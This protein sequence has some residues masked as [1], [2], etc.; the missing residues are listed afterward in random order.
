MIPVDKT[1]KDLFYR[2]KMAPIEIIKQSNKTLLVNI[3]QIAK[4]LHRDPSHIVKYMGMSIGCTQI[5]DGQSFLLNGIFE[6]NRL[7]G[8][9]F[10]YIDQFVLCRTCRNPETK[11]IVE[12]NLLKRRCNSCGSVNQQENHKLIKNIIKDIEVC[13]NED[14]K[15]KAKKDYN[16]IGLIKEENEDNSTNIYEIFKE[17]NLALADLFQEYFKPSKLKQL[18]KILVEYKLDDIL[19]AIETMLEKKNKEEKIKGFIKT[20]C[21][22]NYSIDDIQKFYA[23]Q[24]GKKKNMLIKKNAMLFIENYE[25]EDQK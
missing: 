1:S 16:L 7:Q 13:L 4:S 2:Y 24:K 17:N 8:L 14:N 6:Q 3:A 25:E 11:F 21:E 12:D 22:M 23:E 5:L 9:L 20:M 18:S 15:Y 10:D 19:A